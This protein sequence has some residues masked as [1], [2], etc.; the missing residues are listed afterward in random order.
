MSAIDPNA[1][2]VEIEGKDR[3]LEIELINMVD[4]VVT[5]IDNSQPLLSTEQHKRIYSYAISRFEDLKSWEY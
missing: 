4:R 3:S 2:A 5:L 1:E